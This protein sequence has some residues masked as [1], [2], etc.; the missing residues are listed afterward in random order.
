MGMCKSIIGMA[1]INA[2]ELQDIYLLIPPISLQN[3]FAFI[4]QNIK[5]QKQQVKLQIEQSENLFQSLLQ[6]AFEGNL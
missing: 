4:A 1:N 6:K 5:R 2:Q 3:Q